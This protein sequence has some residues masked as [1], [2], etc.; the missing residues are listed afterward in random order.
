[1]SASKL[2]SF[3]RIRAATLTT[4]E[5]TWKRLSKFL[6]QNEDV[7]DVDKVRIAGHPQ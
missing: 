2:V 5:Y 4:G 7:D 6:L 3:H 1:M